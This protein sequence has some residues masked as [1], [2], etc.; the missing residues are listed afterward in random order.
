[1]DHDV[2]VDARQRSSSRAETLG[3]SWRW[4]LVAVVTGLVA[5]G[6][7]LSLPGIGEVTAALTQLSPAVVVIAVVCQIGAVVTLAQ[8]YRSSVGAVGGDLTPGSA[9]NVSMSAFT[10][11]RV[12]PGGG[13]VG[14]VVAARRMMAFGAGGAVAT[15]AVVLMGTTAM[16]TLA[17]LVGLGA[18]SAVFS[19]DLSPAYVVL[20]TALGGVLVVVVAGV[21]AVLRSAA[22][23]D[24][25][26]AGVER[27][28]GPFNVDMSDWRAALEDIAADPPG[29]QQLGAIVGWS[30]INWA[31]DIAVVW[32][33]F[34]DLGETVDPGVVLVA[35]GM[36][37]LAAAL[38]LTPGGLG[39]VE[40]GMAGT[41]TVFGMAAST[42]V[43]GVLAYRILSYWLPALAGIPPL[44]RPPRRPS[45]SRSPRPGETS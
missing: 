16:V 7:L 20:I 39:L 3:R 25:V 44:L 29:G 14:G 36:A 38:P 18:L 9:L 23:R 41:F 11:S 26:L 17:G 19:V 13:A 6:L 28:L 33:V 34:V 2:A 4:G 30:A 31:F 42:A 12:I 21:L 27:L 37:N 8:V 24:R 32:L 40:A 22:V 43:V 5:Y 45:T 35:Y 10:V 1:M 15:T